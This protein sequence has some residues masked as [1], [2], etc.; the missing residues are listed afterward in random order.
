[1]SK[2]SNRNRH[3]GRINDAKRA[4]L[5]RG[6]AIRSHDG[7]LYRALRQGTNGG[8]TLVRDFEAERLSI[9]GTK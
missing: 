7:R 4:I 8:I 1:M 6:Q 2:R 9:R 3:T 5:E